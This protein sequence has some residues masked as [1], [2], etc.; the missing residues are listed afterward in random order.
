[1]RKVAS[2]IFFLA[3]WITGLSVGFY[4]LWSYMGAPGVTGRPPLSWPKVSVLT[5]DE[6]PTLVLFAHPK[7][8]C[9]R[10]S[11]NELN[12]IM[13]KIGNKVNYN[14][15]FYRPPGFSIDEVK[16]DLWNMVTKLP[17]SKTII[18]HEGKITQTFGAKT[19][20]QVYLYAGGTKD[21]IFT[22]GI[23]SSRGHEGDNLGSAAIVSY[24][25]ESK[26][27]EKKTNIYGCSLFKQQK[28]LVV[29]Q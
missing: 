21:L 23:T 24:I 11:I 25:N 27:I 7:C 17:F 5:H 1:M 9:S 2:I 13:A 4:G 3:I 15:I 28:K 8:P 26:R 19:S 16:S 14:I 6:R 29:V 22:G 12:R 10:A 18:D 20:G